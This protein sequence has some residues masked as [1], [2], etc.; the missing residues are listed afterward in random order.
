MNQNKQI[1]KNQV[2]MYVIFE[3]QTS[4]SHYEEKL[5]IWAKA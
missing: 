3:L 5:T 2:F 1:N 4:A